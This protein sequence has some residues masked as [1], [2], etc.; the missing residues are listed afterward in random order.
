MSTFGR[1]KCA[2]VC[3][4]V[5]VQTQTESSEKCQSWWRKRE[6]RWKEGRGWGSGPSR[7]SSLS[8]VIAFIWMRNEFNKQL[9]CVGNTNKLSWCGRRGEGLLHYPF[10][11]RW[12]D[13]WRGGEGGEGTQMDWIKEQIPTM[14]SWM[15]L[16]VWNGFH[17][18]NVHFFAVVVPLLALSIRIMHSEEC[19]LWKSSQ[20]VEEFLQFVT[21]Q[22]QDI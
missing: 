2:N 12:K 21:S 9:K 7:V 15:I 1:V 6:G 11:Y 19:Y 10:L 8:P 18:G 13:M 5:C 4:C 3:V 22:L 16:P 20:V 17:P 14:S